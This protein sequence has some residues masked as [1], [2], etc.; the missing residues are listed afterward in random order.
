MR[1]LNC[2]E[3]T[4]APYI[5]QFFLQGDVLNVRFFRAAFFFNML[6]AAENANT[7]YPL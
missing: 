3:K 7:T 5:K 4:I 1:E 6:M 2:S